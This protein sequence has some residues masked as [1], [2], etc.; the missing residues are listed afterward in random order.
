M[1]D[2]LCSSQMVY[3]Y[4]VLISGIIAVSVARVVSV[5][6]RNDIIAGKLEL[7]DPSSIFG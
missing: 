5:L 6:S 7:V 1:V 4:P 3:L 2:I